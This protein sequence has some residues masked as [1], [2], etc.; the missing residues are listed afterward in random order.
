M[1]QVSYTYIGL[2]IDKLS[3]RGLLN[4][5]KYRIIGKI[6]AKFLTQIRGVFLASIS[7]ALR[8]SCV[9]GSAHPGLDISPMDVLRTNYGK[10]P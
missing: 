8:A 1:V 9:E 6:M 4:L 5:L 10:N 7:D 3:L 2:D